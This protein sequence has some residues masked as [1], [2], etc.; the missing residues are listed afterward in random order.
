MKFRFIDCYQDEYEMKTLAMKHC[1]CIQ[2]KRQAKV[3]E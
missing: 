2:G 1:E 3:Y